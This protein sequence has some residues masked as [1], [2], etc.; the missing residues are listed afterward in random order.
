MKLS[1]EF[2]G[3]VFSDYSVKNVFVKFLYIFSVDGN[4]NYVCDKEAVRERM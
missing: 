2:L 3:C 1:E 4:G